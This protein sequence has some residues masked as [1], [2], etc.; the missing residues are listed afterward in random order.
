MYVL[1]FKMIRMQKNILQRV[2]GRLL[3]LQKS[4]V[5]PFFGVSRSPTCFLR[6]CISTSAVQSAYELSS[7][8]SIAKRFATSPS[9][10]NSSSSEDQDDIE[11]ERALREKFSKKIM[12]MEKEPSHSTYSSF[13]ANQQ[14]ASGSFSSFSSLGGASFPFSQSSSFYQKRST[15][16]NKHSLLFWILVLMPLPFVFFNY[17]YKTVTELHWQELPI[18]SSSYYAL[19]RT[20]LPRKEQYQVENEY[21]VVKKGA[22]CLTLEQFMHTFYPNALQGYCTTQE[23]VV[24]AVATCLSTEDS[25][26]FLRIIGKAAWGGRDSKASVDRVMEAL[27]RE[28]PQNF[29]A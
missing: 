16:R 7:C 9:S 14:G 8:I 11:R 22:P 17:R 21:N 1:P 3:F 28:Y 29:S 23:E 25:I 2:S 20:V 5:V 27:R 13:N 26:K 12:G 10:P 15:P 19:I 4:S 18:L 6:A 24:A